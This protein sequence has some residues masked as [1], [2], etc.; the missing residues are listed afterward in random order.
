MKRTLLIPTLISIV[1]VAG[2][3]LAQDQQ[4]N[5]PAA[6]PAL[7]LTIEEAVICTGI[8]DRVPQGI[9]QAGQL[10]TPASTTAG[11]GDP[12][13]FK[14]YAFT[15]ISGGAPA[16]I[17]HAWYYQDNLV[18][19]IELSVGGTP[20]RTWSQKEI[21][22]KMIGLWKLEV[23]DA[24]GAVLKTINFAVNEKGESELK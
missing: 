18:R 10:T 14:L 6:Q 20:W 2:L 19:T 5:P 22:P 1:L 12:F 13:P 15:K 16:T 24:N 21:L 8:A 17:K 9:L 4:T 3:A 23:Q 7:V 11:G